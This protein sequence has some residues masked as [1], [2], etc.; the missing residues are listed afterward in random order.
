MLKQ[1]SYH[2][3]TAIHYAQTEKILCRQGRTT[4][5]KHSYRY[6]EREEPLFISKRSGTQWQE[7]TTLKHLQ[8]AVLC[9]KHI[10]KGYESRPLASCQTSG[11]KMNCSFYG[12]GLLLESRHAGG[13][14]RETKTM[15]GGLALYPHVSSI[16]SR[17]YIFLSPTY[18][19]NSVYCI[20]RLLNWGTS[21]CE[22]NVEVWL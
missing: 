3:E 19:A 20:S 2:V 4:V 16:C 8:T 15:F 7:S 6:V 11:S 10:I 18:T 13:S 12:W 17:S 14:M 5:Q 22:Y 9:F 1:W 21:S